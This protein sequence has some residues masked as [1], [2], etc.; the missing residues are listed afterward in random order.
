MKNQD[1]RKRLWEY[2]ESIGDDVAA[3]KEICIEHLRDGELGR[4]EE[5]KTRQIM[6]MLENIGTQLYANHALIDELEESVVGAP[7]RRVG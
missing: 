7:L 3:G 6:S 4:H 1:R 5:F 2:I